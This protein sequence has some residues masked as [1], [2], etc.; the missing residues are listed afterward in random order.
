LGEA[1]GGT[2]VFLCRRTAERRA[3][4]AFFSKRAVPPSALRGVI[5]SQAPIYRS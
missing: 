3:E 5:F 2:E 4:K 1:G